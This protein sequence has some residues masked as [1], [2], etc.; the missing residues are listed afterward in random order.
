MKS[1]TKVL[2][3]CYVILTGGAA[4]A[5][6]E[7][8][9]NWFDDPF[10]QVRQGLPACPLPLGPLIT[11]AQ[12]R[13]EAHYR[14]ERGTSCWMEG[15]C[16]KPNAYLYDAPIGAS[17]AQSFAASSEFSDTSLWITVQRR[18]VTVEGCISRPEQ[19]PEIEARMRAIPDVERVILELMLPGQTRVPY[20]IAPPKGKES[21]NP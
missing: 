11:E 6:P 17:I 7:E 19:G 13:A 4:A 15:K 9:K 5:P 14:I 20:P 10:I 8:R 21:T 1:A 12:R 16:A 18:F 3:C 2:I